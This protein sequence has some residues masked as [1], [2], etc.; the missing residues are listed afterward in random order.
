VC[1]GHSA[2][3]RHQLTGRPERHGARGFKFSSNFDSFKMCLPLLEKFEIKYGWK[4][5][6]IRINFP[7]R[8]ISR[9]ETEVELKIRELL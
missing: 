3:R 8:N 2:G 4:E 6:E 7:Y 5:L 1:H 9:F